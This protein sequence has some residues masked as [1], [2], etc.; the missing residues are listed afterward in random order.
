MSLDTD[1]R[2]CRDFADS[3]SQVMFTNGEHDPWRTLGVQADRHIN[4]SAF[5]RLATNNI[6]RC[7]E[8]PAQG[9]VFG[10]VH[11]GQVRK[12]VRTPMKSSELK[13]A[14]VHVSDMVSSLHL[15]VE[16]QKSP[17]D[18]ALE[19]FI[20]ALDVW[21]PCFPS[22]PAPYSPTRLLEIYGF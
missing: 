22:S 17:F 5:V 18:S 3:L 20:S 2:T 9:A 12:H 11:P 1:Q 8:A 14:Q 16:G 10:L 7:N 6:S 21:L 4:P 13:I 19:L 15:K